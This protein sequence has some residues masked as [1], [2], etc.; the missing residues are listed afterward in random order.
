[1]H[2]IVPFVIRKPGQAVKLLLGAHVNCSNTCQ[3]FSSLKRLHPPP[4]QNEMH[5][6]VQYGLADTEVA[7]G[8]RAYWPFIKPC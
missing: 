8:S 7:A 4:S 3:W 6:R 1:M 5:Q 2:R